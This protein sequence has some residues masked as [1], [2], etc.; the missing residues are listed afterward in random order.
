MRQR[1]DRFLPHAENM[2][3]MATATLSRIY[4]LQS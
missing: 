2:I 1:G 3:T 4:W